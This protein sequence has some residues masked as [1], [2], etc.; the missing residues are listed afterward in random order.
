MPSPTHVLAEAGGVH[1]LPG[2]WD[3][4]HASFIAGFDSLHLKQAQQKEKENKWMLTN[5]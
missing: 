3:L 5:I 2:L 4:D 1:H